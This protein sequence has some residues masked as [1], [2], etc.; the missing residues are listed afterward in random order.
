MIYLVWITMIFVEVKS[1]YINIMLLTAKIAD[2]V[3]ISDAQDR[4][5]LKC[6]TPYLIN[7]Q[8]MI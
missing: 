7:I 6:M 2:T 3:L 1:H 4:C 5:Y 8:Q